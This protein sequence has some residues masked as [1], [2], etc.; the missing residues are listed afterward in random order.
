MYVITEV[1][2]SNI[3]GSIKGQCPQQGG[4]GACL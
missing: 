4:G 1:N 2:L 3:V